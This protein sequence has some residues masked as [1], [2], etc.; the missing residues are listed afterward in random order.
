MSN[1]G[2][3]DTGYKFSFHIVAALNNTFGLLRI[4]WWMDY[5]YTDIIV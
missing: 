1:N 4:P 5:T 3:L 2:L